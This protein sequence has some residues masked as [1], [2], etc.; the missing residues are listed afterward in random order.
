MNRRPR[1]R[2]VTGDNNP[3]ALYSPGKKKARRADLLSS[4]CLWETWGK[5]YILR[6]QIVAILGHGATLTFIDG[7]WAWDCST[8]M[9]CGKYQRQKAARRE[10]LEKL[11]GC[12]APAEQASAR[13]KLE[14]FCSE[15]PRG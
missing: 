8:L 11:L 2:L 1:C 13:K 12:L 4:L 15:Q 9:C 3:W 14:R 5:G 7:Q 10:A 6:R